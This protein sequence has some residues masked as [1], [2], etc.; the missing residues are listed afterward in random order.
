MD[1]DTNSQKNF[2]KLVFS[3]KHHTESQF[4][5]IWKT[6]GYVKISNINY[7]NDRL[8]LIGQDLTVSDGLGIILKHIHM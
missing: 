3:V 7:N 5:L 4:S 6:T 8:L 1:S 2:M